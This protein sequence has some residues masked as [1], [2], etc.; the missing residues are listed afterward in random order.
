MPT[1]ISTYKVT[2]TPLQ[3]LL[4]A[5]LLELPALPLA[6]A[7][8]P[9]EPDEQAVND[10]LDQLVAQDYARRPADDTLTLSA[11]VVSILQRIAASP[12]MLTVSAFRDWSSHEARF[13]VAH[14][15]L[16]MEEK[17]DEQIMLSALRDG[18][19][20]EQA[21]LG[22]APLPEEEPATSELDLGETD[23][24]A[25]F[26]LVSDSD[27]EGASQAPVARIQLDE[28]M[29]VARLDLYRRLDASGPWSL[30]RRLAW[31]TCEDRLWRVGD[32]GAGEKLRLIPSTREQIRGDWRSLIDA[33]TEHYAPYQ[34]PTLE[35]VNHA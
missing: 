13:H 26:G 31:L 2:L 1:A 29:A 24:Q 21:L 4:L 12:V 17:Q 27:S 3:T 15:L 34:T 19:V 5:S 7:E 9:E 20:L 6:L 10:A 23:I 22:L 25:A 32:D 33:A 35:E 14:D 8:P 28:T 16:V 18:D 11:S 30:A